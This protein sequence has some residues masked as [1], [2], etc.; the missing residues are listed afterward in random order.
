MIRAA[1]PDQIRFKGMA[2]TALF[3]HVAWQEQ[4]GQRQ[5][6]LDMILRAARASRTEGFIRYP[7]QSP[8]GRLLNRGSP[9]SA[10]TA[11]ILVS[12]Y[13]QLADFL[14]SQWAAAALAVPY[15]DEIGQSVVTVLLQIAP[16]GHL[17][18]DVPVG[19]W[20]WLKKRPLL[21]PGC[22]AAH[23]RGAQDTVRAIR[24]LG[25]I[26]ILTSYLYLVW[27]ECYAIPPEGFEEMCTSIREDFGGTWAGYNREDLIRRLD[28]VLGQLDL[29]L[30]YLRQHEPSLNEDEIQQMKRQYGQLEEVLLE[31][32]R[33]ANDR[34]IRESLRWLIIPFGLL[35]PV[36]RLW[37]PPIQVCDSPPM[38]VV[39][40]PD[41]SILLPRPTTPRRLSQP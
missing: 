20:S 19:I 15:T 11:T 4:S 34:R 12:P 24:R 3:S 18:P 35:T 38:I 6:A 29:G 22:T 5:E 32:D 23:G 7:Y 27:S 37:V 2:I 39:A 21:P 28:Y 16:L 10:K 36:D 9:L 41:H 33:E 14:I 8:I 31:V 1:N 26:E 40:R 30:E 17:Q 25:D 13:I